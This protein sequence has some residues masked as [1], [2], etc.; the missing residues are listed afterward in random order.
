MGVEPI[1]NRSIPTLRFAKRAD[2]WSR[3][4]YVARPQGYSLLPSTGIVGMK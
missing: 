1:V 4:T 3:T 2:R